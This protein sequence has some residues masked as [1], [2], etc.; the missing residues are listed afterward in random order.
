[1]FSII[2]LIIFNVSSLHLSR[3]GQL[4]LIVVRIWFWERSPL[5]CMVDYHLHSSSAI[6]DWHMCYRTTLYNINSNL[7]YKILRNK[8]IKNK[9]MTYVTMFMPFLYNI[10]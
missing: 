8:S 6:W 1:M 7:L 5:R 9:N 4:K 2:A 3:K 10:A